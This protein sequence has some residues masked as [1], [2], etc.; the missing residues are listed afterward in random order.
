MARFEAVIFDM[1]GVLIDSEPLHFAVLSDLLERSGH[2]LTR[3][4]N[5]QFIGTTSEAM[6]STLIARHGLAGT[7][8]KYIA[9][10][11]ERLLRVLQQPHDPAPGVT[12]LMARLR[13]LGKRL[14]VA[15]SSRR[16]W[17]EATVT[18]LGL[19]GGFD[20]EVTG[21]DVEHGKPDPAIYLLTSQR[22]GVTPARCV[23][24]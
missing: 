8:A 17:V 1:D 14:A 19:A 16:A 2:T 5:E 3:A 15:S 18:S 23:A 9:R 10:Y 11:D 20:A 6:F 13:E 24:I 7:V 4:E 22:L 12:A 21:D